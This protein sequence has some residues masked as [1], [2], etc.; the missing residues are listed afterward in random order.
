MMNDIINR[1]AI[2]AGLLA[3]PF[4]FMLII[5]LGALQPG[6]SHFSMPMSMLGGVLGVRGLIFNIGV[7]M[8]GTFILIFGFGLWRALPEKISAK[9]GFFLLVMGSLGLIGAGYFHCSIDCRNILI[10]PDLIGRLHILAS[11]LAGMGTGLAP[12]FFWAA[13]RHSHTWKRYA[14]PTLVAAILANVP[15][16]MF[17]V[18]FATGF[19]LLSI[20]G[21]IQ[22]LGFIVV[23]I[24]IFFIA[25]SAWR[26]LSHT[27]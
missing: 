6:F 27:E 19:R 17:W 25:V 20:E 16:V 18:M 10:E 14:T 11:L 2:A 26:Q 9:I 4:Y 13:M 22:R 5:S 24:W 7:A 21:L 3:A 1:W 12:F 23:L 15:G 8:T